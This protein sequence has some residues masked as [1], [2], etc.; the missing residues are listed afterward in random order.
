MGDFYLLIKTKTAFAQFYGNAVKFQLFTAVAVTD[1]AE[2]KGD[3]LATTVVLGQKIALLDG[4]AL[5]ALAP[6]PLLP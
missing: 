6:G 2:V 3:C 5:L 4:T 1:R